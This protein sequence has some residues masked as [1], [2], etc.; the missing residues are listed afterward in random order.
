MGFDIH[1]VAKAAAGDLV[2]LRAAAITQED[3]AQAR[4]Q[5]DAQILAK[6]EA[7]LE[8][9]RR[10]AEAICEVRKMRLKN[11]NICSAAVD[12][13]RSCRFKPQPKQQAYHER[14]IK[15]MSMHEMRL[16]APSKKEEV[17]HSKTMRNIAFDVAAEIITDKPFAE[18][19]T[20]ELV[21]A[22]RARLDRVEANN[23]REAFGMF[24]EFEDDSK[25][26]YVEM[27]CV[28]GW[29]DACWTEDDKPQR[30]ATRQEAL[31]AIDEFIKDQHDAVD[32]GFMQDKYDRE[33]YRVR[34]IYDVD[35]PTQDDGNS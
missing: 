9:Q 29:D 12:L 35:E 32:Q 23:E 13:L 33:D 15:R 27:L 34:S 20:A 2:K 31:D 24:D 30:F 11:Q 10:H 8:E 5:L 21:A 18:L 3:I 19:T 25:E 1:S 22:M 17:A 28:G 6:K 16:P 26:F 14:P 4:K 7:E